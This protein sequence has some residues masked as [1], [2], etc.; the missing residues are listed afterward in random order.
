MEEETETGKAPAGSNDL[1]STAG[2]GSGPSAGKNRTS[3][4]TLQD[5]KGTPKDGASAAEAPGQELSLP[6]P[7][8]LSH[9]LFLVE[10]FHA[11][12]FL[13]SR[14]HMLLDDLRSELRTYLTSLR[15]QLVS[16]INSDYEDFINLGG[17]HLLGSE[18]QMAYRMRKPLE[19][20]S[21]EIREAREE[22]ESVRSALRDKLEKRE[23]IRQR[24]LTARK[25]L[26]VNE[27]L[28]KVEDMLLISSP[29]E[30]STLSPATRQAPNLDAV[31][32]VSASQQQQSK[33]AAALGHMASGVGAAA[34]KVDRSMGSDTK[35]LERTAQ[36]YN[37]LL[38]L[39]RKSQDHRFVKSLQP[40]RN[41]ALA[42]H[43]LPANL[44][45]N[46]DYPAA[47][48]RP[49]IGNATT[50]SLVSPIFDTHLLP[51]RQ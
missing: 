2:P 9:S 1:G 10:P 49:D 18:D 5:G 22:L 8:T 44:L 50:R 46:S 16:I 39:V 33:K 26:A 30:A 3:T 41:H 15:A 23:R 19:G 24:K 32:R 36:E 45:S 35:R 6:F 42:C 48:H 7:A 31:R 28:L 4:H 25:L 20:I 13:L 29:H 51:H 34:G 27:Q 37:Q 21:R 38:Y 43:E 40:V 47:A 11:S 17:A 12:D 14:K